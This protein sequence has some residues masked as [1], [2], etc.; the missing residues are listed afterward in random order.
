MK[1]YLL[2]LVLGVEGVV[3]EEV[4]GARHELLE[5]LGPVGREGEGFHESDFLRADAGGQGQRD[6]PDAY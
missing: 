4:V 5:R 6:E 1:N 2:A 3:V